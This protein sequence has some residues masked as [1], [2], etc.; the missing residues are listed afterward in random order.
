MVHMND[1][2]VTLSS[3]SGEW[4]LFVFPKT[5]AFVDLDSNPP[6]TSLSAP[7]VINV[8]DSS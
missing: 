8:S 4:R 2:H 6:N 3:Y 5:E 1:D 7:G